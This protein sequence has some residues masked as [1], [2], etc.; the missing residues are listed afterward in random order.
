MI[1]SEKC[2]E[3]QHGRGDDT[4][5][6]DGRGRTGLWRNER[7]QRKELTLG[8]GEI[9]GS[10]EIRNARKHTVGGVTDGGELIDGDL[11]IWQLKELSY[12]REE[13]WQ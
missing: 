3:W 13:G 7:Y 1:I 6:W 4:S 5:G 12:H 11:K 9:S 8:G 10:V 2:Q